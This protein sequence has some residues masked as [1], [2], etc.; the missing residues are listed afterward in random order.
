MDHSLAFDFVLTVMA[1]AVVLG[2]MIG[3]DARST[4]VLLLVRLL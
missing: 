2:L 4:T 1:M 3:V